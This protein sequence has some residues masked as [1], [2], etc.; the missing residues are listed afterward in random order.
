M[1]LWEGF[2]DLALPFS[3][4]SPSL[5]DARMIKCQLDQQAKGRHFGVGD[6]A[7]I[8][9][10]RL[11]HAPCQHVWLL[12]GT[13][14]LHAGEARSSMRVVEGGDGI[15]GSGEH[16]NVS[17]LG[18]L[19]LH[20]HRSHVVPTILTHMWAPGQRRVHDGVQGAY[21]GAAQRA[22]RLGGAI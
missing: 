2:A 6:S 22:S 8:R 9:R 11:R 3:S 20:L 14:L 19:G 7:R 1:L 18:L 17:F 5:L 21:A 13:A 16:N 10:R 15:R 4:L 12:D